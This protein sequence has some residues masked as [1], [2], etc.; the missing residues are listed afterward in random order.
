M[1]T[2]HWLP[3]YTIRKSAKARRVQLKVCPTKGLE[4]VIPR[5]FS[6]HQGLEFLLANKS[7]VLKHHS[8][9]CETSISDEKLPESFFLKA[10][11]EHWHISYEVTECFK[12]IKCYETQGV[13]KFYGCKFSYSEVVIELK[14]WLFI[15]AQHALGKWLKDLS[16]QHN[17]AYNQVYIKNQ[18]TRWGSCS[19]KKNIN[20]N[21]KLLFLTP[22]LTHYV[23]IHELCHL[24]HLD[25]SIEFWRL[26]ECLLPDFRSA[27]KALKKV[28][29][30]DFPTWIN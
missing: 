13:L 23:L 4:L 18:K 20:L 24:K 14:K 9:I 1:S 15:K 16:L 17:L 12:K 7:W 29:P 5:G 21:V 26:L 6:N 3:P 25:H 8:L 10:F 30:K 19:S 27:L 22:Q 11:N 28:S 2:S